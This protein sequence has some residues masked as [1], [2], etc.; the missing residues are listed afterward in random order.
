MPFT[1]YPIGN[2]IA[3][4]TVYPFKKV[5]SKNFKKKKLM[6]GIFYF[7]I[8]YFTLNKNRRSYRDC[9]RVYDPSE[10]N[11]DLQIDSNI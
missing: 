4:L 9:V 6:Y 11:L 10:L 7:I 1:V 8:C 5:K 2:S 3:E